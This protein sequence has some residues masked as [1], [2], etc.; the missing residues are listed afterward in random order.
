MRPYL[1]QL[2]REVVFILWALLAV[3]WAILTLG[4][5]T[6]HAW[7]CRNMPPRFPEASNR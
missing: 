3:P 6:I 7:F 5:V 4:T 1:E 2:G